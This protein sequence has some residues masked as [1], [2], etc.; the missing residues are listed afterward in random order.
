M[1][2]PVIDIAA[3]SDGGEALRVAISQIATYD[4]VVFTSVNA[5]D[6]V[7]PR[8]RTADIWVAAV[9]MS[10]GQALR[11]WGLTPS[12]V[13]AT[14]VAES[15]VEE[16]PEGDG[17]V[18]IPRAAVARDVLPEGLRAKGWDVDIVEAYRTVPAHPTPEAVD[19]LG[20]ADAITFTSASTVKNYVQIAGRERVPPLVACIGPITAQ[21]AEEIGVRVDVTAQ[22]HT[23]DGL[24]RAFAALRRERGGD[25]AH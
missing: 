4:W 16:F 22:E 15:L 1:T 6:R 14:H 19:A 21:A 11:S 18:L 13:P 2:F 17:R 5:V 12:L 8:I 3:P 7:A 9:G 25:I 20:R 23:I 10:T 24:V